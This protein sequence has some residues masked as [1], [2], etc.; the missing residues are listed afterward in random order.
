MLSST[1]PFASA[2]PTGFGGLETFDPYGGTT[3]A[4]D[5]AFYGG[6]P[7][8]PGTNLNCGCIDPF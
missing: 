2:Q 6:D 4:T 7:C 8:G 1:N 5:A 3:I